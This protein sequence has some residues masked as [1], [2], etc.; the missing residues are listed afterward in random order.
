MSDLLVIGTAQPPDSLRQRLEQEVAALTPLAAAC[1]LEPPQL[2]EY[3]CGNWF[4]LAV[5]GPAFPGRRRNGPLRGGSRTPADPAAV[6]GGGPGGAAGS[7][8]EPGSAG[9]ARPGSP[10]PAVPWSRM[11][12]ELR[13]DFSGLFLG[14][15]GWISGALGAAAGAAARGAPSRRRGAAPGPA[16]SSLRSTPAQAAHPGTAGVGGAGTPGG[17]P[18]GTSGGSGEAGRPGAGAESGAPGTRPAGAGGGNGAAGAPSRP[19][20]D[21]NG[22]AAAEWVTTPPAGTGAGPAGRGESV[23]ASEADPLFR[24]WRAR[25]VRAI[26]AFIHDEH[27]WHLMQRLVTRRYAHLAPDARHQAL[28]YARRHLAAAPAR[29]GQLRYQLSRQVAAYVEGAGLLL[30]DGFL[31]FRCR[32][33]VEAL[34]LAVDRAVDEYLLDREYRDFVR[35]LRQFVDLQVP[36]LDVVHVVVEPSGAFTMTDEQG[37]A[38]SLPPGEAWVAGPGE[39][40]APDPGDALVSA[41]VTVAARRFVVHLRRRNQGL[42]GDT[43][44]MLEQVFGNRVEVCTGCTRCRSR[45]RRPAAPAPSAR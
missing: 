15:P 39:G 35:L 36:R 6:P 23:P 18:G 2:S 9:G 14:G 38:V 32:D 3:Q 33:Y 10:G 11:A 13:Y 8:E 42:G 20:G 45:Q 22:V 37:R 5:Q 26:V 19:G 40:L 31:R 25:V 29:D 12:A 1:G 7:G 43:R 17:R 27:R 34:E 21:P 16:G 24:D 4:F 28:A 41:L 30:V 44:D